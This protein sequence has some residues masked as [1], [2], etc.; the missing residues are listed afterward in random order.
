MKALHQAKQHTG[1]QSKYVQPSSAASNNIT[2]SSRV[3]SKFQ[4]LLDSTKTSLHTALTS[5]EQN[6]KES[7]PA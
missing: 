5:M 1:L 4:G 6:T 3:L 7:S 2:Y